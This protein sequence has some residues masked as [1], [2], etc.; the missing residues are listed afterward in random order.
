MYWFLF[1]ISNFIAIYYY[2]FTAILALS[3]F[4]FSHTQSVCFNAKLFPWEIL[5]K[6]IFMF[7]FNSLII[8]FVTFVI[9]YLYLLHFFFLLQVVIKYISNVEGISSTH[10][11]IRF[12][13]GLLLT[14]K[15]T[16]TQIEK[17][18]RLEKS[19]PQFGY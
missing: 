3:F 13:L 10:T 19:I 2:Y 14:N 15:Q 4:P 8:T 16:Y 5:D 18:I 9:K 1:R 12:D 11:I 17:Q 6:P 7:S